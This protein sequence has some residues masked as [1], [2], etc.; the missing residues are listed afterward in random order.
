MLLLILGFLCQ[1]LGWQSTFYLQAI[2][3]MYQF[4]IQITVSDDDP[5]WSKGFDI[6][7]L[8]GLLLIMTTVLLPET[9]RKVKPEDKC[10]DKKGSQPGVLQNIIRDFKPMFLMLRDWSVIN[11]TAYHSVIFACL[12]FMVRYFLSRYCIFIIVKGKS[13]VCI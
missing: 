4:N 10:L 12:Y 6:L 2:L 5:V 11:V 9:L 13:Y 1:Y 8:G 7:L 3:S